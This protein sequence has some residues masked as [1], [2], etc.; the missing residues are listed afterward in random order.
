[1]SS[2]DVSGRSLFIF[3]IVVCSVTSAVSWFAYTDGYSDGKEHG[4]QLS[5]IACQMQVSTWQEK[6]LQTIIKKHRKKQ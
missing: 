2:V 6:K 3:I 5:G 1:M 4:E